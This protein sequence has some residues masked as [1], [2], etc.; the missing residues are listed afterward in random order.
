MR[1]DQTQNLD[2]QEMING[3][4]KEMEAKK[5]ISAMRGHIASH[6]WHNNKKAAKK[7]PNIFRGFW[8][9]EWIVFFIIIRRPWL[10]LQPEA[11]W[12][13]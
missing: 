2:F 1:D 4:L 6:G 8:S 11:L 5:A 9:C 7:A 13:L 12:G 10:R 3:A